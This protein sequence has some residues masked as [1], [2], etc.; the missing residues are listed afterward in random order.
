VG[1]WRDF[2]F[3]TSA[4]VNS[5]LPLDFLCRKTLL[6]ASNWLVLHSLP[7][8][9]MHPKPFYHCLKLSN[10]ILS[11]IFFPYIF[12]IILCSSILFP[13]QDMCF[14]GKTKEMSKNKIERSYNPPAT[15]YN[16][17][18]IFLTLEQIQLRQ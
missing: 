8:K 11:F 9:P 2:F 13:C 3:P 18:L 16:F 17:C 1:A 7:L 10:S 15:S 4:G 12:Y 5:S 14:I 6:M